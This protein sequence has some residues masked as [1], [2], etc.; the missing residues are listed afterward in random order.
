M[1]SPSQRPNGTRQEADFVARD[2]TS[3]AGL[4]VKGV[5][6]EATGGTID[7]DAVF[8]AAKDEGSFVVT[9]SVGEISARRRVLSPRPGRNHRRH[10]GAPTGKLMWTGEVP[11]A[12]MDE[13]LHE[14]SLQIRRWQ[15]TQA[16]RHRRGL[17]RRRRYETT[18]RRNE[19]RAARAR[20]KRRRFVQGSVG[21]LRMP[22]IAYDRRL[23]TSVTIVVV[24]CLFWLVS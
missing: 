3:M 16:D 22:I 23:R 8:S 14:G 19:N 20:T 18:S 11:L 13:L 9:A 21:T 5:K 15:R 6:W 10:P 17:A 2:S 12:E 4:R 1:V 24:S 7:K